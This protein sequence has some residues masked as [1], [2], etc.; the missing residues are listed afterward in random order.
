LGRNKTFI[1]V[2][3]RIGIYTG[4]AAFCIFALLPFIWML[5]TS[6]KTPA[7]TFKIPVTLIPAHLTFQA[8]ISIL[9]N[10]AWQRY[11]FNSLV[12]AIF[13]MVLSVVIGSITGYGFSRF[14]FPGKRH[15]LLGVVVVN[16]FPTAALILPIYVFMS[17]LG[18]INTH[19]ALIIIHLL[20]TLPLA[21]WLLVGFFQGVSIDLEEAAMIDGCTRLQAIRRIILPIAAPGLLSTAIVS[22][23]LSWREFLFAL[24]LTNSVSM[25]TVPV[26]IALFSGEVFVEWNKVMA[27][28]VLVILPVLIIF[29]SLGRY[30][31]AGIGEGAIKG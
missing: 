6:L 9:S 17:R 22:F 18:I 2:S 24:I 19:L 5:S 28:G 4:I 25:R 16:L 7:D 3:Q 11:F 14:N 1:L 29:L 8:Y 20:F 31:I 13:V 26:G 23:L 12:V 30:F 15:L 21:V 27:A 10:P